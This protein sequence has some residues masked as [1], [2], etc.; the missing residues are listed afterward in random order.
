[1][2]PS[3]NSLQQTPN[4]EEVKIETEPLTLT[5]LE[6]QIAFLKDMKS[7]KYK[8]FTLSDSSGK[9]KKFHKAVLASSN[10]KR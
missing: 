7:Q 8:D 5:P 3:Q 6:D 2:N 1:M 4:M 9:S 10:L